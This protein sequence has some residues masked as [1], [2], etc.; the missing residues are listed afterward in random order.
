MCEYTEAFDYDVQFGHAGA[1]A[2]SSD[3]TAGAKNLYY[4][5]ACYN[6]H[7]KMIYYN[8]VYCAILV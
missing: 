1:R 5:L 8:I 7:H 3:E 6:M 2:R 4:N